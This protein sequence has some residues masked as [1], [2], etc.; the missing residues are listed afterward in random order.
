MP[1][2]RNDVAPLT[3]VT[4]S[5]GRQLPSCILSA[6]TW[7]TSFDGAEPT[8]SLS[9]VNDLT[10]PSGRQLTC[11]PLAHP[12]GD[13]PAS[14]EINSLVGAGGP[15]SFRQS[16]RSDEI[17]STFHD[18]GVNVQEGRDVIVRAI[19]KLDPDDRIRAT[20][21]EFMIPVDVIRRDATEIKQVVS[22]GEV[23]NYVSVVIDIIENKDVITA[24]PAQNIRRRSHNLCVFIF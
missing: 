16:L 15:S 6:P 5:V 20:L 10:L 1:R 11:R 2:A 22:N 14:G 7:P 9:R 4:A 8:V 24:V 21:D 23:E 18:C 13:Q 17:I 19:D 3:T 12:P